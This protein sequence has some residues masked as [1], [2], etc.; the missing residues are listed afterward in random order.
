MRALGSGSANPLDQG[1]CWGREGDAFIVHHL[2]QILVKY[3]KTNKYAY[4]YRA[5]V[6]FLTLRHAGMIAS[7]D[8]HDRMDLKEYERIIETETKAMTY[9]IRSVCLCWSGAL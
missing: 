6:I 2:I 3:H 9:M 4:Q 1:G 7:I 5:I 8:V